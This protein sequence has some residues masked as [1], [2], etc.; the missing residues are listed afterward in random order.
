MGYIQARVGLQT[1]FAMVLN[2]ASDTG[3]TSDTTSG[4]SDNEV[5]HGTLL[6]PSLESLL[7]HPQAG[8]TERTFPIS[9]TSSKRREHLGSQANHK[10]HKKLHKQANVLLIDNTAH[11]IRSWACFGC[12]LKETGTH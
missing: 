12:K 4:I 9:F 5:V 2:T 3:V 11:E 7:P 10:R 6:P 8:H 1:G